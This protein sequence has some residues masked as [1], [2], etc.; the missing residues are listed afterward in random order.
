MK[1]ICLLVLV[2]FLTNCSGYKPI[3]SSKDVNFF[4]DQIIITDN[5]KI[6]YKIKKKLKPYSSENTNKIKINLNINSSKEVKIIAK[7]NKGD[8]LMFNL[9]INSSIEI[10]SNDIVEKK[11][12]FTEKFTFKNQANKFEL[13]Q[14]K[15][16]LEDELIDKIF[17]K[18]ILNLRTY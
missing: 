5:D 17:E 18:L 9:V 11:Y 4:I 12:K 10:L 15:R 16:S 3:F 6:S 1:K 14:Y 2:L 13:E 7:D 8:A